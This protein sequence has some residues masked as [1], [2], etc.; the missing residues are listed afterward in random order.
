VR[1]GD[2]YGKWMLAALEGLERGQI[3]ERD[4]GF[5]ETGM[6]GAG[7][8]LAPFRRWPRHQRRAMRF[9]RGRALDVEK[10]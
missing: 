9:V 8:Y 3:V 7:L 1:T 4:D 6:L 10:R 2:A 5:I